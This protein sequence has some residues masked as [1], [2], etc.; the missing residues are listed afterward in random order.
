MLVAGGALYISLIVGFYYLAKGLHLLAYYTGT[1]G[2]ILAGNL[3][4]YGAIGT[5]AFGA[6]FVVILF[7]WIVC[8]FSY[9]STL[10]AEG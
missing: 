10:K 4:F 6:G 8:A 2:Y 9:Y 3:M 1:T 7:G 5:I